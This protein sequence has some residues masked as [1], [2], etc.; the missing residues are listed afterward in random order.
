MRCALGALREQHAEGCVLLGDSGYY[1]RFGFR[2][3]PALILPGVPPEYFQAMAF[4]PTTARGVV[5]YHDAF[6]VSP[7]W[8]ERS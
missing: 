2:P 1:S 6:K 4:G 7:K 3:A 8:S 5:S